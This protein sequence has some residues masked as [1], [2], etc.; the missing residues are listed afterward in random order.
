MN[1]NADWPGQRL[2]PPA[3]QETFFKE[4]TANYPVKHAGTPEEVAEAYLFAMKCTYFTGQTI[5]VDGG[6]TL[7]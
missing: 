5:W 4:Y 2:V 6:G 7:V 3:A 1:G